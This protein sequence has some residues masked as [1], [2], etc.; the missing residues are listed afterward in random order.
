MKIQKYKL[1][2]VR[3]NSQSVSLTLYFSIHDVDASAS[4]WGWSLLFNVKML[5]SKNSSF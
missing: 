2:N 1:E 5:L 3:Q 4:E